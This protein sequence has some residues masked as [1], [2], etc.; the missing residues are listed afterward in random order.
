MILPRSGAHMPRQYGV[1]SERDGTGKTDLTSVGMATQ[2]HIEIGMGGLAI[3]FGR[4]GKENRKLV[5]RELGRNLFDVVGAI[6]VSIVDADQMD[7]LIPANDRLHFIEQHS[8]AHFFHAR[9]HADGI[10]VSE[11]AVNR[12]LEVRPYPR[13]ALESSVER[14]ECL[15]CE[16]TRQNTDV[17]A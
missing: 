5:V 12:T 9:N 15:S 6:V 11:H 1:Q 3:D 17:I 4:M 7:A 13:Q 10:M 8:D 2:Q 14:P 16:V